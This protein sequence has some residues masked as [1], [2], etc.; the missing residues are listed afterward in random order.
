MRGRFFVTAATGTA[1]LLAAELA[2]AGI[3]QARE[4]QGGVAC[5]GD[6]AAAYRACLGSRIG[7]RVLWQ[8]ARFPADD[9]SALY[10]GVRDVDWSAHMDASGTLVVDFPAPSPAS[11]TRSSARSASRTPSSTSFASAQAPGRR[12]TAR[13]RPSVSTCMPP[14]AR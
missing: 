13:C 3:A 12:S 11:R 6:L 2:A 9:A 8:L 4:V 14:A 1:D 5:E 7:L 10:A